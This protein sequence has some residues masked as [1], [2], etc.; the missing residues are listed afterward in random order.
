MKYGELLVQTLPR[1]IHNDKELE[2]A[3]LT[4]EALEQSENPSREEQEVFDLLATLIEQ[5]EEKH[6]PIRK[7]TPH[8]LVGFLL[9]QRGLSQKDLWPLIGSKGTASEILS[10]KRGISVGIASKLGQFFHVDPALFIEWPAPS[11]A[12]L[13]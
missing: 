10:G 5:Y 6:Y 8:E 11:S 12:E 1:V 4:L 13:R 7:A 2:L 9:D 3:T